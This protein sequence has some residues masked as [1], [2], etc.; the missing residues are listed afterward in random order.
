MSKSSLEHVMERRATKLASAI[1][2][3]IEVMVTFLKPPG[4]PPVFSRSVPR[5]QALDFWRRHRT[6]EVGAELLQRMTPEQV[7]ALDAALAGSAPVLG[8]GGM[9]NGA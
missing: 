5:A 9:G 3:R 2:H 8:S 4:Q 6:D 7:M 1:E